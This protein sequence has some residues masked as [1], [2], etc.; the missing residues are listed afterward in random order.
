MGGNKRRFEADDADDGEK[1][2]EAQ[3]KKTIL[4]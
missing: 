2:L 1:E 4:S 3:A